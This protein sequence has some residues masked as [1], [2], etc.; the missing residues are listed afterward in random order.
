MTDFNP[1]A[2]FY[3]CTFPKCKSRYD[4][5]KSLKR[6]IMNQHPPQT[7]AAT[8]S[9]DYDN[10][11]FQN[12]PLLDLEDDSIE[13]PRNKKPRSENANDSSSTFQYIPEI[14]DIDGV[15]LDE[16]MKF[17]SLGICRLSKDVSLPQSK[18]TEMVKLCET[19][20]RMMSEYFQ[21]ITKTFLVQTGFDL[22]SQETTSLLNS[23]HLPDIFSQVSTIAKQTQFL[24]KNLLC[25][26][27]IQLR[28]CFKFARTFDMLMDYRQ[29][30]V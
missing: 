17:I 25:P 27:Q 14:P 1:N 20:V 7:F 4:H 24:K 5:F 12:V 29:E 11:G 9:S 26:C 28:K 10:H 22:A 6:H 19:L 16:I 23:F 8:G 2:V 15:S 18:V 21:K 3:D 13:E 30:F